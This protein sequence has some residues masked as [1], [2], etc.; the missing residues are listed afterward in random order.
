MA[1]REAREMLNSSQQ[2]QRDKMIVR[3]RIR[4]VEYSRL[5][6]SAAPDAKWA[7]KRLLRRKCL[8]GFALDAQKVFP[9]TDTVSTFWTHN[10]FVFHI[11]CGINVRIKEWRVIGTT[12]W[13]GTIKE[14]AEKRPNY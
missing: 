2:L 9:W 10:L 12:G 8:Q 6:G 5:F 14:M 7:M 13:R 4:V 3:T 11:F 1:I